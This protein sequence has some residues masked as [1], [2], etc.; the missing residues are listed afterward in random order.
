[1]CPWDRV[2]SPAHKGQLLGSPFKRWGTWSPSGVWPIW[3]SLG[4]GLGV[5]ALGKG[6]GWNPTRQDQVFGGAP[7]HPDTPS[8][9][10]Y[11]SQAPVL[12]QMPRD[13]WA[14]GPYSM[15]L[16]APVSLDLSNSEL[17]S[18][19]RRHELYVSFQ[20]LGW[21]VGR[22]RVRARGGG[23]CGAQGGN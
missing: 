16:R 11:M 7:P 4:G 20:D 9:V 10:G 12:Q 6:T 13:A 21:Q 22:A 19:C 2:T 15:G 1:M 17:K 23:C 5:A 14:R 18:A 8:A 3:A